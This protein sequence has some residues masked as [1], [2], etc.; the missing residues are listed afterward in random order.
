MDSG[1]EAVRKSRGT[2]GMQERVDHV[3]SGNEHAV[4][5]T[6]AASVLPPIPHRRDVQRPRPA[7][8][9]VINAPNSLGPCPQG[10]GNETERC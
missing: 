9:D 10:N 2:A 1:S 8:P 4:G 6:P 3:S 7:K 5:Q